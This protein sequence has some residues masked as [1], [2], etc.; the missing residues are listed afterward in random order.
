MLE[1]YRW[2]LYVTR[3]YGCHPH[4]IRERSVRFRPLMLY[5]LIA[6]GVY[7]LASYHAA[8]VVQCASTGAMIVGCALQQI[9]RYT[10]GSYMIATTLLS[11]LRHLEFERGVAAARKFDDLT[12]HRKPAHRRAQ[13]LALLGVHVAWTLFAAYMQY[14]VDDKILWRTTTIQCVTRAAFSTQ[15]AKFCFLFD[16]LRRRFRLVNDMCQGSPGVVVGEHLTILHLQR[17]HQCLTDAT[18]YLSSHYSPQLFCWLTFMIIDILTYIFFSIYTA[19]NP[20]IVIL[21][22]VLILFISIQMIVIGGVCH[23]TCVQEAIELGVYLRVHPLRIRVFDLFNVN[24]HFTF[25]VFAVTLMYVILASSI[26]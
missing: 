8:G 22:C 15:V 23:L 4:T 6:C 20:K 24:N 16:A 5:S 14:A 13:W 25:L 10:R 12:R 21:Q 11:C 9:N 7:C 18:K 1:T 17:L 2:L 26:H 19:S 3:F